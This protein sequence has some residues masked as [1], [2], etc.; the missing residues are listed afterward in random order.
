MTQELPPQIAPQHYEEKSSNWSKFNPGEWKQDIF[1]IPLEI[2]LIAGINQFSTIHTTSLWPFNDEVADKDPKETTYPRSKLLPYALGTSA[3]ILGGL[4][5]YSNEFPT[6]R[7]SI[8]W[9]HAHLLTEVATS[10][11]K[12]TFQRKRPYYDKK[13]SQGGTLGADDRYSFF[14]GHASHAFTFATYSSALLFQYSNSSILNWTYASLIYTSAGVIAASRVT[15]NAHYTSDVITGAIVGTL[16]SAFVFFRVEEVNTNNK[17]E[18]QI[19]Y[20]FNMSPI[21]FRDDTKNSWYGFNVEF[22]I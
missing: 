19:I 8:G 14:S 6:Y 11:A 7:H 16:I 20:N 10:T 1:T 13:V 15:D 22:N 9:I 17:K 12:V 5:L 21:A 4:S 3:A 18:E 2:G